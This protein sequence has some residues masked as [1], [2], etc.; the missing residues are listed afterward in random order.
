MPR[1][2]D[3]A[4]IGFTCKQ[5]V[6]KRALILAKSAGNASL[7]SVCRAALKDYLNR[8]APKPYTEER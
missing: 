8:R 7:G 5:D 1:R 3:K 4:Y 2:D 6:K